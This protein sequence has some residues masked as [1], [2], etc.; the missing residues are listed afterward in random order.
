[1]FGVRIRVGVGVR[2]GVGHL[3]EGRL[4]TAHPAQR[5]DGGLLALQGAA[6]AA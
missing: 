6:A 5:G 1:M 4:G 2:V 3:V